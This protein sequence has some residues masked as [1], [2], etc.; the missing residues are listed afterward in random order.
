MYQWKGHIKKE[1][2]TSFL[3]ESHHLL[4]Q[5][6]PWELESVSE[7]WTLNQWGA[8]LHSRQ[9]IH[10]ELR[11]KTFYSF[12]VFI[13]SE[14]K[15]IFFLYTSSWQCL[16]A[17]GWSNTTP[18]QRQAS[19]LIP[20]QPLFLLTISPQPPAMARA[21]AIA[22]QPQH[23]HRQCSQLPECCWILPALQARSSVLVIYYQPLLYTNSR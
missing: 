14:Y 6:T 12:I 4:L 19:I 10:V 13:Y 21:Q 11:R 22:T 18:V 9:T 23:K 5:F 7:L 15:D 16:R 8:G 2:Y 17:T 20:L 1:K 3:P